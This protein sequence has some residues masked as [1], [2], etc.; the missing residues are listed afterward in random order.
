MALRSSNSRATTCCSYWSSSRWSNNKNKNKN[1]EL[2][3]EQE[4]KNENENKNKEQELK[5]EE[6][7]IFD[8]S[9]I[10]LSNQRFDEAGGDGQKNDL[11]Q[12]KNEDLS[13][14]EEKRR[15]EEEKKLREEEKRKKDFARMIVD[16]FNRKVKENNS[17]IKPVL[18]LTDKRLHAITAR[19]KEYGE[20]AEDYLKTAIVNA[21]TSQFLNG[22]NKKGWTATFDWMMLPNNFPKVLEC[23]Y[24]NKTIN[25]NGNGGNNNFG[26]GG[27]TQQDMDRGFAAYAHRKLFEQSTTEVPEPLQDSAGV[28]G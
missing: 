7:N 21:T 11:K 13:E 8:K 1:K 28:D 3:Q 27:T 18:I 9:E 16:F 4:Q 10:C 5:Q 22:F 2:K 19:A 26:S 12:E 20:N 25:N 14:E 23:N 17:A 6:N 15:K 24:D